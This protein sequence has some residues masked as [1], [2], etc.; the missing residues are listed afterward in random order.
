MVTNPAAFEK[1]WY[2]WWD[3]LQ[4]EWHVKGE[5]GKWETGEMYGGEWDDELMVWGP[6]GTL[7][8]IAGLYFWGCT[9]ADSLALR[10]KWEVAVNDVSWILEGLALYHEQFT[11]RR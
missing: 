8:I 7:S 2:K 11:K 6:N 5:D 4:P 10:T 1:E 3:S 9:I